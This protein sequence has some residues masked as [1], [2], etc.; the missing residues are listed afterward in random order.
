MPVVCLGQTYDWLPVTQ[1]D[2]QFKEV[3][4][5]PGA[6]AVLLYHADYITYVSDYDQSEFVY[7][8]I[9][10]LTEAGKSQGDV[11]IPL[12]PWTRIHD[13]EAR[14]IQ[15][16]GSISTLTSQPYE[17]VV[18]KGR[19]YKFLALTFA[20]PNLTVGSII[21]YKYRLQ[22][23]WVH[24]DRW[25]LEH[26]LFTVREHFLFKHTGPFRMSF[27]VN[28]S[29]AKPLA[30]NN[31][32]ELELNEVPPFH[33]EEQMPPAENYKAS[34]RF[35]WN[36]HGG[37]RTFWY[38]QARQWSLELNNFIGDYREV[39]AA[40]AEAIGNATDADEKIRRLYARAQEIRNLQWERKLTTQELKKEHLKDNQTV[41]D[42][43][44]HGHGGDWDITALFVAMARS[45]GF[46]AS[47]IL[48]ASREHRFF[49]TEYL[50]PQ[51]YD[52]PIA[53]VTVNGKN[54]LL[55]PATRFCPYGSIRWINTGASALKM[56]KSDWSFITM[57]TTGPD[58]A[59]TLRS[60]RATLDNEGSLRGHITVT[61]QGSDALER[62][63]LALGTDEAGQNKI[64]ENEVTRWLP[65]Q[66]SVKLRSSQG[67]QQTGGPVIGDFE[68]EIPSYASRTG[69]R[70]LLPSTLFPVKNKG[71]FESQARKYP[72]YFRYAFSEVDL[73]VIS[74]PDGYAIESLPGPEETNGPFGTY[75]KSSKTVAQQII[76][77]RSLTVKD[78]LVDPEKY[79]DLKAF[80]TQ[81]QTAD[82]N[83]L[84]LSPSSGKPTQ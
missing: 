17:R 83:P 45:A 52:S 42:V 28:G 53:G 22:S 81:V 41:V 47:V 58:R 43:L 73:T 62:Q 15:P 63:L 61:F 44:K 20:L 68:I 80:F 11:E 37:W 30:N 40:A 71:T 69:N 23:T 3:P 74:V 72:V 35:F 65:P 25:E 38:D 75:R 12:T 26:D 21:E 10:V 66:S 60:T 67:W 59:V 48:V 50:K 51:Q 56:G 4:G 19:N 36:T 14:T 84:V 54:L 8:R 24:S 78:P 49:Q 16:D 13:L 82:D 1:N 33:P 76:T 18:F 77:S 46:D 29:Q 34:V 27:V 79:A 32:F 57:P 9:K 31:T 5:N 64:L 2:L 39:R 55:E 6:A 7:N 70:L